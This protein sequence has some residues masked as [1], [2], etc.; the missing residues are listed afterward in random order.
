MV[1]SEP[2]SL[3]SHQ[4][5]GICLQRPDMPLLRTANCTAAVIVFREEK[6]G[7]NADPCVVK[8]KNY[9]TGIRKVTQVFVRGLNTV[10]VTPAVNE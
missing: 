10:I 5:S 8:L 6:R 1:S 2:W 4:V 7:D 3:T 9:R